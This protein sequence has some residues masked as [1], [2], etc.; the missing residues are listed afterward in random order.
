MLNYEV[1]PAILASRVP[2]HTELEDW[3]G[4]TYVSIV[5]FLFRDTRIR[6]IAFPFHRNFEEVNLRFYVRRKAQDEWRRGVVFVKEIVP[7]RAVALVARLVYGENYQAM[8]MSH[9]IGRAPDAPDSLQS[10]S[11]SWRF[12]GRENSLAVSIAGAPQLIEDR[13]FDEFIAEH[14]WGY[15]GR[16]GRPTIEYRVDHPRWRIW[17]A[18]DATLRCDVAALYGSEFVRALDQ[19]P[20]S[21]LVAEG[22]DVTVRSG[23]SLDRTT[24]EG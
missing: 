20:E 11:Y 12:Q 22:S 4:K 1:D 16:P 23:N 13:S 15:S 9:R 5:G 24:E 17:R 14:D 2:A 3:G 19:P 6:G 18:R 10:V 8:P 21:A 7:R